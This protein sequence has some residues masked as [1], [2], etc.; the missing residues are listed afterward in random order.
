MTARHQLYLVIIGLG[1]LLVLGFFGVQIRFVPSDTSG[2]NGTNATLRDDIAIKPPTELVYGPNG[3]TV[4]IEP[5]G[6]PV[7]TEPQAKYVYRHRLRIL[8][9]DGF[10]IVFEL[11]KGTRDL[12]TFH[13]ASSSFSFS[14]RGR[15]FVFGA[16]GWEGGAEI[17]V[18]ATTG[19]DVTPTGLNYVYPLWISDTRAVL[20]SCDC[21]MDGGDGGKTLYLWDA[22]GKEILSLLPH[23]SYFRSIEEV[24]LSD[25]KTMIRFSVYGNQYEYDIATGTLTGPPEM[26]G[27]MG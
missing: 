15:Y 4:E 25:D 23:T 12:S 13:V 17:L 26:D 19:K 8:H 21:G 9:T 18:D 27:S 16:M 20:V 22:T 24:S 14:P 7:Y 6:A 11:Q 1:S 2:P 3:V 5:F 10:S